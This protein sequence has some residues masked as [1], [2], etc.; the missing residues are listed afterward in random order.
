VKVD[1][2]EPKEVFVNV[3]GAFSVFR[4]RKDGRNG[5]ILSCG[6]DVTINLHAFAMFSGLCLNCQGG[7][8]VRQPKEEEGDENKELEVHFALSADKAVR[9]SPIFNFI[10]LISIPHSSLTLDGRHFNAGQRSSAI[11]SS[12]PMALG[13]LMSESDGLGSPEL[14]SKGFFTLTCPF[15]T[16]HMLNLTEIIWLPE[17]SIAIF[18]VVAGSPSL[19][20]STVPVTCHATASSSI[21]LVQ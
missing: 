20:A 1:S 7:R 21:S 6:P 18:V 10:R 15:F 11:C 2:D 13:S 17:L 12:R 4:R 5:Q 16:L 19:M 8:F 3:L 9:C 14:H